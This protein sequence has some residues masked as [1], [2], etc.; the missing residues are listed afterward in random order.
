MRDIW[1][2]ANYIDNDFK[3]QWKLLEC[4]R[5]VR[6]A[7]AQNI[8]SEM[9]HISNEWY[10]LNRILIVVTDNAANMKNAVTTVLQ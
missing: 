10:L 1:Q 9:R 6:S 4:V 3:T 7:T 5:F 8:V 2:L